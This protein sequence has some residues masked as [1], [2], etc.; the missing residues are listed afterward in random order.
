MK[1]ITES[2]ISTN[3]RGGGKKKWTCLYI[4]APGRDDINNRC[5]SDERSNYIE[6]AEEMRDRITKCIKKSYDEL[7]DRDD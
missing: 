2:R 3:K 7:G 1:N 6:G 4:N 5:E